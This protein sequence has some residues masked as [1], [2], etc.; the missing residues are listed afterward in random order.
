MRE[1]TNK[2]TKAQFAEGATRFH[3]KMVYVHTAGYCSTIKNE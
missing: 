2:Q 3:S 1:K